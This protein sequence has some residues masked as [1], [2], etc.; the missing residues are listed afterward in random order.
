MLTVVSSS[1]SLTRDDESN[2]ILD[3]AG[4]SSSSTSPA[5]SVTTSYT[6][7]YGYDADM[8]EFWESAAGV[9]RRHST[10]QTS[11]TDSS[12]DAAAKA[13][14]KKAGTGSGSA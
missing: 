10:A 8:G 12:R 14:A 9:S 6:S 5:F 1:I 4:L 3:F 11:L 2:L 7:S 13:K